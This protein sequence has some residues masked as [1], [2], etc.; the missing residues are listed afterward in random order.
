MQQSY[1]KFNLEGKVVV[2]EGSTVT[3]VNNNSKV[4]GELVMCDGNVASDAERK[5]GIVQKCTKEEGEC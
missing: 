3:C 5:E 4:V 1:P 2:Q